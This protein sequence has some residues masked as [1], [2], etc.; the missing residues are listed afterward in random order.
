[1][2]TR[3]S[4]CVRL[5]QGFVGLAVLVGSLVTSAYAAKLTAV[6]LLPENTLAVI[7]IPNA[8]NLAERFMNTDLGRMTQDPQM[9]PLIDK[10][11]SSL[12][13]LIASVQ[14]QVGLSLSEIVALPQGEVT[15]AMIAVPDSPPAFVVLADAGD[16][17]AN[18]Q[19]LMDRAIDAAVKNGGTKREET[20]GETKMT[21][22]DPPGGDRDPHVTFVVK[23]STVMISLNPE[24]AKTIVATWNGEKNKTL[25]DNYNFNSIMNRCKGDKEEKPQIFWFV[26]PIN[27]MRSM[28]TIAPPIQVG[29][30]MLPV[31]GMDGL[32]AIGGGM[33]FDAGQYDSVH[34]IHVLLDNP[35]SGI[36]KMIA[37][38]PGDSKPE[39]WVPADVA[40]YNTLHCNAET[41]VKT[42]KPM[43][44]SLAG[45]GGLSAMID[46]RF[47][48]PLG[49]DIEK[50]ILPALD[51]RITYITWI[52]RPVTQMSAITLAG[53]KFK[54]TGE[55]NK[56]IENLAKRFEGTI[57]KQTCAGK[58]YYRFDIPL[59]QNPNRPEPPPVP[60]PCFGIVDDYLIIANRPGLYEKVLNN[61]AE[62]SKSLADDMEFKLIASKI[63]RQ[64]GGAKPVM[65]GFG[66]PE[67][68]LR[69]YYDL[70]ND[71]KTRE[72]MKKQAE[73]NPFMKSVD[74]ALEQYPLPPFEVI[75]RYLAPTGS[76]TT[77]DDTGFH[78]MQF[79]LRRKTD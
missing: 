49:V 2:F 24:V 17:I 27:F 74:S 62:G 54:D 23:D 14:D 76:V 48:K 64:S 9:K 46:M 65:L 34:H 12:G 28:A 73:R 25:A 70:I 58:N 16:Q 7:S 40:S 38:E 6:Q 1:M 42:L 10:L 3:R 72:S 32:L 47:S 71:N 77:D 61:L 67:E 19:K 20:V 66:R 22:I 31:L 68:S 36:I 35:R 4:V 29:V 41:A 11:Y 18:A 69:Y 26:D 53:I 39:R 21:I 45:E 60:I 57:S 13:E 78:I 8:K 75:Q 51:G 5:M 56:A 43:Y 79:T 55:L 37:L 52:E 30:A 50:E 44:D 63:Q 59:P 15:A 33:I